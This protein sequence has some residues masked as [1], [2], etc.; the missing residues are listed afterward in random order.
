[1]GREADL[2]RF[3]LKQ[4]FGQVFRG[5]RRTEASHIAWPTRLV[6]FFVPVAGG[7]LGAVFGGPLAQPTLS[8]ILSGSGLL[9]GSMLTSF[10]FL[11]N[12]RIKMSETV[13]LKRN[14]RLA[15]MVSQTAAA[16]L[17]ISFLALCI[18]GIVLTALVLGGTLHTGWL[19]RFGTILIIALGLHIVLLF[20]TVVRR[21]FGAYFEVFSADYTQASLAALR[22]GEKDAS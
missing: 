21:L 17:Y 6:V 4:L 20:P 16:C 8:A 2:A 19:G 13:S 15:R 3:S 5:L 14:G 10:V 1:M 12:L 18:V 9:V 11:A 22:E 7:I